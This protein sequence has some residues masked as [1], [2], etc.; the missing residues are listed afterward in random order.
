MKWQNARMKETLHSYHIECHIDLGDIIAKRKIIADDE[1]KLKKQDEQ[2]KKL[3]EENKR[4]KQRDRVFSR[5]VSYKFAL[6]LYNM[7]KKIRGI[8]KKKA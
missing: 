4:L 7:A 1:K 5:V 2:I 8:F 3:K 6:K